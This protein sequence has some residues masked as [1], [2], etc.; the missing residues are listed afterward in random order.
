MPVFGNSGA[1]GGRL[2]NKLVDIGANLAHDSFDD[3]RDTVIQA[4]R[5]AGVA[6]IVVTGSSVSS[7]DDALVLARQW[8]G[9]L[10]STAGVHPHHARD[11][12]FKTIERLREIAAARE[13]VAVGECGLDYFRDFSPR[14]DQAKAFEHQLELAAEL[15]M[16]VFLHERAAHADFIALV[17]SYIDQLPR[18]VAHCFTGSADELEKNLALGLYIGITGWICDEKRG[19]HL[20][21]LVEDIPLDRLLIETDAPYLLPRDLEPRPASRRNEPSYLPHILNTI[22]AS[23]DADPGEIA[24]ATAENSV[25][26]FALPELPDLDVD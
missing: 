24:R 5:D 3:D 25:R 1:E 26:F 2:V 11:L 7:S 20:K 18:A 22:A 8:P 23:L 21:E 16:P 19:A 10:F 4:A 13:V 15:E 14:S 12:D 9:F 17:S 6:A